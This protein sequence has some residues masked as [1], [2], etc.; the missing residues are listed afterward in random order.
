MQTE[1]IFSSTT[2]QPWARHVPME[3]LTHVQLTVA[4]YNL[5]LV[6]RSTR[7]IFV[8]RYYKHWHREK[9]Q[10]HLDR[11]TLVRRVSPD[12]K[13]QTKLTGTGS[14]RETQDR[15]RAMIFFKALLACTLSLPR[16]PHTS[17]QNTCSI[18]PGPL[19]PGG[20]CTPGGPG[21]PEQQILKYGSQTS[22]ISITQKHVRNLDFDTLPK[23]YRIR[24]FRSNLF[25][26]TPPVAL[27]H[28]NY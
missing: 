28:A 5:K 10:V 13:L 25:E 14:K 6:K 12:L 4:Y 8:V 18:F 7:N 17:P 19:A 16:L 11:M 26:Q 3:H 2:D 22:R 21:A 24:T 27:M 1:E 15:V 20:A 9:R 23:A